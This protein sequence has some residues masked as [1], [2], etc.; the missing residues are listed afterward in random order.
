MHA[1]YR[2][3]PGC[4]R[5]V[6]RLTV[7]VHGLDVVPVGVEN[8]G[9]VVAGAIARALSRR[10]VVTVAGGER[11]TV[12]LARRRG[13]RNRKGEVDVLAR[14]PAHQRERAAAGGDVEALL[15]LVPDAQ[16]EDRRDRLVEALRRLEVGDA[17]PEV[18]DDVLALARATVVDSLGAAAVRVEE[19]GAVVVVVVLGPRA[20]LAVARMARLRAR[21]QERVHL[22]ARARPERDV[23]AA[24]HRTVLARLRDPE[25]VPLVEMP[26]RMRDRVAERRE[27]GL[28]EAPARLA[29]GDAGR[30]V[31]EHVRILAARSPVRPEL[32]RRAS[33][34][35]GDA[36]PV[37][38]S[39]IRLELVEGLE[40]EAPLGEARVGDR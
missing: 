21:V 28:V 38:E 26:A 16:P 18:V 2:A 10:A 22:L 13:V 14:L 11:A 30:D 9:A 24:R 37:R 35:V 4:P 36:P 25:V 3:A 32:V 12:E 1:F 7:V 5:R 23:Q 15:Q 40:G 17:D 6:R 29:V 33:E 27:D 8:V 34:E 19:E 39:Q 20:G 31:V